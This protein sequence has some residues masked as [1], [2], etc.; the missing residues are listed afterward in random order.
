MFC[1]AASSSQLTAEEKEEE[2]DQTTG[3]HRKTVTTEKDSWI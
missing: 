2:G 3:W 1:T